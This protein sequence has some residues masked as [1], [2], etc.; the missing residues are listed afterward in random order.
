MVLHRTENQIDHI[1]ATGIE[2]NPKYPMVDIINQITTR[3]VE[4]LVSLL[5]EKG[6]I[7]TFA[8]GIFIGGGSIRLKK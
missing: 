4:D 1:M 3:Y 2:I 8:K 7:L 5:K 6:I